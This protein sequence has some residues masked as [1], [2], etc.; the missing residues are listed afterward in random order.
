MLPRRR[1]AAGRVRAGSSRAGL[2]RALRRFAAGSR[3]AVAIENALAVVVLVGAFAG[4]MEIVSTVFESD[5]MGRAARAAAQ[6][7]ALDPNADSC[8]AIR[9]ELHLDEK[10][11]CSAWKITVHRGVLASEL[12]DVLQAKA[13]AGSGDMVLVR[14]GW[15]RTAWSFGNVVPTAHA[16]GEDGD[17][18]EGGEASGDGESGEGEA[19]GAGESGE[20]GEGGEADESGEGGEAGGEGDEAGESG[21]T[22]TPTLASHIAIGVARSEPQD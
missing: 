10:F 1:A 7:T 15:S 18:G 4:L 14:I 20:A 12:G 17:A 5:R 22:E 8:A 19:G 21:S 6:A 11:D 16:A 9:R 3:G 2:R 13:P